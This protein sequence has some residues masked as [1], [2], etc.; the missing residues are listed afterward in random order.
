MSHSCQKWE[1]DIF[2]THLKW[3]QNRQLHYNTTNPSIWIRKPAS[4]LTTTSGPHL[5]PTITEDLMLCLCPDDF[6]L[7]A[8]MWFNK[9][10]SW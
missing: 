5:L 1:D 4:Y 9:S 6:T 2:E 10:G 8:L 7:L 3:N